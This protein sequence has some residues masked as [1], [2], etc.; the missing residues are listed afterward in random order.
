MAGTI[1]LDPDFKEF[2]QSL[3]SRNVRYLVAGGYAVAYYGRPRYTKELDVWVLLSS[4]NA[5]NL[6]E[7]LKD[8]GFGSLDLQQSDFLE[9]DQII[10]L[11][12]PPHRIDIINTLS[13]VS[14]EEFY[15]RKVE[16]DVDGIPI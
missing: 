10:Q 16:I 9:P 1:N 2:L 12:Y 7:A 5:S 13:G 14:F 8:F 11:G 3:N 15:S 6:V 4:S